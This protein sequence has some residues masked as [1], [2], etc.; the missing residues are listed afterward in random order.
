MSRNTKKIRFTVYAAL[1][2]ALYVVL[3]LVFAPISFGPVQLRISEAL[4]VLP[5]FTSAAIP[6]LFIGCIIS[7]CFASGMIWADIMFGSLATLVAA[8]FSYL[9]RRYKYL[10]PLPAVI[11][12]A[13]VVPLVLKFGYGF[14][15]ALW[16][17][18]LT[19]GIG[20][21]GACYLFGTPLMLILEKSRI[22]ERTVDAD[23]LSKK[24]GEQNER[25]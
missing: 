10:V 5:Y 16:F 15:D 7:N 8:T 13:L 4:C 3:S 19:V 17:M 11:L 20:Q 6:G 14:G 2:A 12:N 23:K 24:K 9:L 21:I 22:F 1:I 18:M 25:S